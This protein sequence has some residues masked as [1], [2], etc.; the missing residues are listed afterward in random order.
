MR[1][2]VAKDRGEG[3]RSRRGERS[4]EIWLATKEERSRRGEGEIFS[5]IWAAD[6]ERG[7]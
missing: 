7:M 1:E 4:C 2:R 5:Q 3:E 6:R